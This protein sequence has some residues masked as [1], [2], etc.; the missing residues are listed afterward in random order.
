MACFKNHR[1]GKELRLIT[2]LLGHLHDSWSLWDKIMVEGDEGME[3]IYSMEG[4]DPPKAVSQS[5]TIS[6][7]EDDC[8]SLEEV[9]PPQNETGGSKSWPLYLWGTVIPLPIALLL[10]ILLVVSET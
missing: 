8:P 1:N 6:S 10:R 3:V 7:L 9:S 4:G 2:Q 5:P